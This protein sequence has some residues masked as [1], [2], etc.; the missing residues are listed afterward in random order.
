MDVG[1]ET[2]FTAFFCLYSYEKD[3]SIISIMYTLAGPNRSRGQTDIIKKDAEM[4]DNTSC[5]VIHGVFLFH[6]FWFCHWTV[7]L[8]IAALRLR[9]WFYTCK[10]FDLNHYGNSFLSPMP[11]WTLCRS[12]EITFEL[13]FASSKETIFEPSCDLIIR[14]SIFFPGEAH[15]F[16]FFLS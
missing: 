1:K 9:R 14:G 4:R 16:S 13:F 10:V 3:A 8:L 15:T 12:I 7:G 2:L 5:S 11:L 6:L